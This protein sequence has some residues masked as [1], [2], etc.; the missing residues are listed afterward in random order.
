VLLH[1]R[2][3][4]SN[5]WQTLV[6]TH[7]VIGFR[8]HDVRLVAAMQSYGIAQL[9]T[10]NAGHFRGLPITVLDPATL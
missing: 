3:E 1:D 7:A 4:L 9:L 5:L 6:E 2:E 8:A 10:F